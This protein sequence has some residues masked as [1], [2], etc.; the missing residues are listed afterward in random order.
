MKLYCIRDLKA[1]HYVSPF[2]VENDLIAV[3]LFENEV[4]H[5]EGLPRKF[6]GDFELHRIGGFDPAT[7]AVNDEPNSIL[8]NG[9]QLARQEA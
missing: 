1:A 9:L 2:C 3:R 5:G 6:P 8:C 4:L 7:G